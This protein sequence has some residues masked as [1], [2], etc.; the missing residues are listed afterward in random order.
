MKRLILASVLLT[1]S[2]VSAGDVPPTPT[3]PPMPTSLRGDARGFSAFVSMPDFL[4]AK[5]FSAETVSDRYFVAGMAAAFAITDK[6]KTDELA[7]Y[8]AAFVKSYMKAIDED[9]AA[10][11]G[12]IRDH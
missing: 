9:K 3:V 4:R 5:V 12:V 2:F 1:A 6:V 10:P 8:M 7:D 11:D